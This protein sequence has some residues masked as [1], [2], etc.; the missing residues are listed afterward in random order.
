MSVLSRLL[1]LG[2]ALLAGGTISIFPLSPL[3][4]AETAAT[5]LAGRIAAPMAAAC[6]TTRRAQPQAETSS[7][8]LESQ[9]MLTKQGMVHLPR[10]F[11][12]TGNRFDLVVHFHGGPEIV[13]AAMEKSGLEAALLTYNR[14]GIVQS[15]AYEWRYAAPNALDEAVRAVEQA[16]AQSGVVDAPRV[17]RI[18]LSGWSAGSGAVYRLLTHPDVVS[19]VDA[20]LVEDGLHAAFVKT[21]TREIDPVKMAPFVRF[22]NQAARGDKLFGLTHSSIPTLDHASTTETAAYIANA[23]AVELRA[24]SSPRDLSRTAAAGP[25]PRHAGPPERLRQTIGGGRGDFHVMGF[26]GTS[27]LAHCAQLT[28]I[29]QTLMGYLAARWADP[30]RSAASR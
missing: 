3:L 29:D 11:R 27:K 30:Q 19:R 26:E 15:S 28:K 25:A 20:V 22:A 16:I 4:S 6:E 8:L 10:T 21:A 5:P 17:R 12:A 9:Q 1:A 18:A 13:G 2:S 23:L 7:I 24:P 14:D